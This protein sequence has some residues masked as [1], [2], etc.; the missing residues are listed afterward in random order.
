MRRWFP[1]YENFGEV[2]LD[3]SVADILNILRIVKEKSGIDADS[4]YIY[5]IPNEIK[6]SDLK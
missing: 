3:K 4:V 1:V 5:V 6:N 2:I